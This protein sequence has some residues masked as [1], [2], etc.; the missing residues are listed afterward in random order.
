[1]IN[2][3]EIVCEKLF[4]IFCDS[5][6]RDSINDLQLTKMFYKKSTQ[7]TLTKM[8]HKNETH[9]NQ[10]HKSDPQKI[11]KIRLTKNS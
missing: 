5:Q 2:I 4:E 3:S 6:K 11:H 8:I 7:M 10:S 9:K 1:M